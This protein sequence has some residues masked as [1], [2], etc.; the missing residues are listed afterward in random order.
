MHKKRIGSA[1]GKKIR[2][3]SRRERESTFKLVEPAP[4]AVEGGSA[5]DIIDNESADSA[6]VV[7]GGNGAESLLAGG[8][9]NL[10][11][12]FLGI[13]LQALGLELD[14]YGGL[15]VHIELVASIAGKEVGFAD[16]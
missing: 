4:H 1:K 12:D 2:S 11:L 14:A 9:P 7:G 15:G 16:R 3:G 5:G 13:D 6:A 8:V 10:S